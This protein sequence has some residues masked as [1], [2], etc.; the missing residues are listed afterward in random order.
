MYDRTK[1]REA[2]ARC[3]DTNSN[4][5]AIR[6]GIPRTTAFRLWKGTAAPSATVAA[7]VQ[8]AYCVPTAELLIALESAA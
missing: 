1:L 2:A 3:G 8:R 7:A 6:L 4:R 5:V